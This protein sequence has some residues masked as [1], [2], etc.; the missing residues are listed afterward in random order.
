MNTEMQRRVCVPLVRGLVVCLLATSGFVSA[1]AITEAESNDAIADA[2][3]ITIPAE[4]LTISGEIGDGSGTPNTDVDFYTFSG[5]QGDTPVIATIGTT[6]PDGNGTCLGFPSVLTL[7]D[8]ALNVLAENLADC[9]TG[10]EAR[11]DNYT[12]EAN[13]TYYLAVAEWPHIGATGAVTQGMFFPTEGGSYQVAISG[14][15]VPP[16]STPTSVKHVPIR[17]KH[18]HHEERDLEKRDRR[19]P[20]TVAILSMGHSPKNKFEA[21]NVDPSTLT[22]GATGNERSLYRCQKQGKDINGDGQLDMICFFNP[23]IANFHTGDRNGKLKG[24]TKSGQQIAGSAALKI[25]TMPSEKRGYKHRHRHDRDDRR[26]DK[27]NR[28]K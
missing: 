20:I 10:T 28:K 8:S 4:G 9:G 17:V 25:F 26:N 13:G 3:Q 15:H 2:Q 14:V 22:F 18:W 5:M 27:D 7:Y 23:E 24:K 6:Q 1:A 12:L 21:M 16:P 11:I 19:D